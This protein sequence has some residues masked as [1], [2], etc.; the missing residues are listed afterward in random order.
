MLLQLGGTEPTWPPTQGWVAGSVEAAPSSQHTDAGSVEATPSPRSKAYAPTWPGVK[1]EPAA[2]FN[3]NGKY[4]GG[5]S[6]RS[7]MKDNG[8][9]V[10]QQMKTAARKFDFEG[11]ERKSR[12]ATLK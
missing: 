9:K 3:G 8:V 11:L 6:M 2:S 1:R 7:W 5:R 12:G 4:D 10:P